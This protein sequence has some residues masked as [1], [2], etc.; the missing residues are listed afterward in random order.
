MSELSFE[1]L[2]RLTE[3]EKGKDKLYKLYQKDL[4]IP[5]KLLPSPNKTM[6]FDDD[7]NLIE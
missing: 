3:I 7:G 4:D 2:V 6:H 5:I 1:D